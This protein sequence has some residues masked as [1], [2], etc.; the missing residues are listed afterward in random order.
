MLKYLHFQ[1]ACDI[2]FGIFMLTWFIARHILFVIVTWSA[3]A[4][5]PEMITAGCYSGRNGAIKGPFPAPDYVKHLLS[6]FRDPE[7]VV[8]WNSKILGAFIAMLT[9]LQI[10]T[11]IWFGMIM[12]VAWRVINGGTADDDRSGD[13]EDLETVENGHM[14]KARPPFLESLDVDVSSLALEPLEE[15]VGVEQINLQAVKERGNGHKPSAGAKRYRRVGTG[16]H[17]ASSGATLPGHSDRKELLGRIGCD[18]TG[19]D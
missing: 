17:S 18:K 7:G 9:A 16:S 2:A 11:L 8:C 1:V 5:S 19:L 12:R 13:E 3:Y 4:H 10:I 6:P 15:E 14:D